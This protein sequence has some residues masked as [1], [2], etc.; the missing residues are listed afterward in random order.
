MDSATR[1]EDRITLRD[2]QLQIME[3]WWQSR[4]QEESTVPQYSVPDWSLCPALDSKEVFELHGCHSIREDVYSSSFLTFPEYTAAISKPEGGP[5]VCKV[6]SRGPY[7]CSLV[8]RDGRP[9]KSYFKTN[10]R[11]KRHKTAHSDKA[12]RRYPC[13]LPGCTQR[14]SRSDNA[15]DHFKTHLR[16][17]PKARNSHFSWE[18]VQTAIQRTFEKKEATM[19]LTR[20]GRWVEGGMPH[21]SQNERFY[22]QGKAEQAH[23]TLGA[24]SIAIVEQNT[25]MCL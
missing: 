20:L 24:S 13:P 9:C 3:M 18:S 4:D 19:L 2:W 16:H 23:L 1:K 6:R 15:T 7:N 5:G 12:E 25:S 21:K 14:S 10:Y 11:L 22:R 17:N 8:G